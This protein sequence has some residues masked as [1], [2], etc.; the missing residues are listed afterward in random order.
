MNKKNIYIFL[1]IK[2]R[3]YYCSSITLI[4]N[5]SSSVS[6]KQVPSQLFISTRD[7]KTRIHTKQLPCVLQLQHK[8]TADK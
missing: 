2:V 1:K 7:H 5:V 6:E 8:G 3:Q 4:D